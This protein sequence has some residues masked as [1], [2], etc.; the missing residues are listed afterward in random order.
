MTTVLFE[1]AGSVRT[2]CNPAQVVLSLL[3]AGALCGLPLLRAAPNRLVSGQPIY[4]LTLLQGPQ[5]A[6][7]AAL[8]VLGLVLLVCAWRG[9]GR[10]GDWAGLT[11]SCVF[12]PGLVWLAAAH[13]SSITQ[14]MPSTAPPI[15]RIALGGGFWLALLLT[16]LVLAEGLQRLQAGRLMHALVLAALLLPVSLMVSMGWCDDLSIMKEYA[17]LPDGFL[18]VLGRHVQIV[19]AALLPTLCLGLP[20]GWTAYRYKRVGN[21]LFPVLNVI[22]TIPSI[23]L[24]GLLMAPL[25]WLASSM[26]TLGRAGISGVGL[27]PAVMALTLYSLLPVV[28]GMLAGLQQVPS[29]VVQAAIGMG[30]RAREIFWQVEMPLAWPLVLGGIRTATIQSIGL[31]AVTALIGAGGLGAIMFEGLFGNAQDLVLL[32]VLPVIALGA[33]ADRVFKLL[34]GLGGGVGGVGGA[35]TQTRPGS[36]A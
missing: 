2:G 19:G 7:A 6:V 25:A 29:G 10:V 5:S 24:F 31:A 36:A 22:Q 27:A 30:M 18:P 21:A 3:L 14:T 4:F 35:A 9:P 11:A 28:R 13:A 12:L 20:L 17:N 15:A 34:I 26:P 33:L 1:P 23:A 16:G 32:G 8:A